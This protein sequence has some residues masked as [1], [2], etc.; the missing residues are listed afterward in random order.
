MGEYAG[1]F[2]FALIITLIVA[3]NLWKEVQSEKKETSYYLSKMNAMSEAHSAELVQRADQMF[4]KFKE[5]EL[6]NIRANIRVELNGLNEIYKAKWEM[7][8]E[9]RIRADALKRS[10]AIRHGKASEILMPFYETF[11]WDPRD[12]KFL[13]NPIDL[14]VFDGAAAEKEVTIIFIEAKTGRSRFTEK[15]ILIKDAVLNKRV[16]WRDWNPGITLS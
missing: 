11:P 14:I 3:Y 10:D 16:V 6:N 1:Y 5:K 12:T 13:G 15:Q 4:A 8:N 9:A 7:E 2:L